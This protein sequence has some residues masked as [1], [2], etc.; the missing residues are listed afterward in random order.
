MN[1]PARLCT[2]CGT[3]LAPNERFCNNCG[4]PFIEPIMTDPTQRASD[5]Y[6][7]QPGLDPT[8]YAPSPYANPTPYPNTSYAPPPPPLP[9]AGYP[10]QY[11]D[12][13]RGYGQQQSNPS[14]PPF[15]QPQMPPQKKGPRIWWI[16]GGILLVLVL[17]CSGLVYVAAKNIN[18]VNTA[19]TPTATATQAPTAVPTPAVQALF[20]DNFADN[21]KNW[22]VGGAT[23]Y[24]SAISNNALT[25]KE[26]NHKIF[27]EPIPTNSSYSDFSI[28]MTFTLMKGDMNDSVGLFLR[29]ATDGQ[30]GYYVDVFGDDT[31]DILKIY[32]DANQQNQATYLA[33]PAPS[34]ALHTEGQQNTMTV[35]MKGTNIVLLFNN[36]VVQSVTDNTFTGGPAFLF[37]ENG[38]S[39]DGVI[40]TF[41]TVAI[42]P[43]PAQLPA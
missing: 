40:A 21:S 8:Q 22:D 43:P 28:A 4:T 32:P 35:I 3:Q 2:Q 6:P 17:A 13:S 24:S 20:S 23:G 27:R 31:Y 9:N 42:Y 12:A 15:P 25:M 38:K 7:S 1:T 16:L 39:S 36:T 34:S 11:P 29:S 5:P 19:P 14:Y 18:T 37:I 26:A 10:P 30:Q 41:N 33:Q